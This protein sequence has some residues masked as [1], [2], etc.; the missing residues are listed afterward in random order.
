[1]YDVGSVV[2]GDQIFESKARGPVFPPL[3]VPVISSVEQ[4]NAWAH[5]DLQ[6]VRTVT[7]RAITLGNSEPDR[8]KEVGTNSLNLFFAN[9]YS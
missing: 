5:L 3:I 4:F 1:M 2:L 9:R 8:A 6:I 7:G